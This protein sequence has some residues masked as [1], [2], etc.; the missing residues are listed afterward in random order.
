MLLFYR[1]LATCRYWSCHHL[2]VGRTVRSSVN[3]LAEERKKPVD[4]E[5]LATV[6]K[7]IDEDTY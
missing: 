5:V 6:K 4:Q 3:E 2:L 1:L 7:E